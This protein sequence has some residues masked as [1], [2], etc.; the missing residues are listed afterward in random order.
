MTIAIARTLC[1]VFVDHM[2]HASMGHGE[3]A[4]GEL[5]THQ[6]WN[7]KLLQMGLLPLVGSVLEL[8]IKM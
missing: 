5:R 3:R 4:C 8:L 1:A 6:K 7:A 2:G